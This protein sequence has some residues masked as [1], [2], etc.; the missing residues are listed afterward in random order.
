MVTVRDRRSPYLALLA[1]FALSVIL[2]LVSPAPDT[3]ATQ[4]P[5]HVGFTDMVD[6]AVQA[7]YDRLHPACTPG[8]V[9][10][11]DPAYRAGHNVQ[12]VCPQP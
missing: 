11:G 12:R 5:E 3:A 7:D 2:L 9:F 1:L 6:P 8:L 4:T 10:P